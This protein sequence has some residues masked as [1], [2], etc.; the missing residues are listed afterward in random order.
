MPTKTPRILAFGP[1]VDKFYPRLNLGPAVE[2]IATSAGRAERVEE[3][4]RER[5]R[6]R[7]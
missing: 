3:R 2:D 1:S 7:E 4:E 6:E 5:E